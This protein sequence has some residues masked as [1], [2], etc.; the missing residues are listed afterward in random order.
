MR[1]AF[2][3]CCNKGV[4]VYSRRKTKKREHLLY[5]TGVK[6]NNHIFFC[7]VCYAVLILYDK[8]KKSY[9]APP[10]VYTGRGHLVVDLSNQMKG[11]IKT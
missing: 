3:E 8:K 4:I 9:F 10:R 7:N 6:F 5:D 11:G 1:K 2:C